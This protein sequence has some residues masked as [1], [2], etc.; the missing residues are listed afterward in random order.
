LSL[1]VPEPDRATFADLGR[2]TIRLWQWGDPADPAVVLLHGGWDHG[3][4]WDGFAP[5]VASLGYHA[6]A[7]DARGHGDSGRLPVSGA[8]WNMF[9]VDLAQ[10]VMHVSPGAPARIIGHSFGG[11]ISLAF[12]ATFPELVDRV[13]NIDG[14]GPAP[15]MFLVQD[16]AAV[17]S[18]WLTDAEKLWDQP[19]REY[20]SVR[21]MAEKRKGINTRLPMEWCEHLA[22]HGTRRGPGGGW[23]WKSDQLFRLGSPAPFT[24]EAL[25][26][27]FDAIRGPV[28]V[29]TG[30]E[31]D[32][33]SDLPA[34]TRARR[35]AAIR[36]SRHVEVPGAGH[37]VHIERPDAAL[38]HVKAFFAE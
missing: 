7:W 20:A 19:P 10:V 26:A 25:M 37:Y 22:A 12:A 11:G 31:P 28:L 21:E 2:T 17:A 32:Q 33:W 18:Q 34:D 15:E 1:E 36:Q 16:H 27:E 3:R 23:A 14:L 4:M 9:L 6:V 38:E 8:F 5:L 24:D 29:L 35:L 13:V 30:S